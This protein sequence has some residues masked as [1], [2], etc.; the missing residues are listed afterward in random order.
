MTKVELR[1][2]VDDA[3]VKA[4][5]NAA[6]LA[7]CPLPHAFERQTETPMKLFPRYCCTK[8]GGT[9]EGQNARWYIQGMNDSKK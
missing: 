3:F 2:A 7:T 6:R 1:Q 8:C 5:E 4:K 9:V